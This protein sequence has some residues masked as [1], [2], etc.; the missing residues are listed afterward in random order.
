[1]HEP[2]PAYCDVPLMF[3]QIVEH[4]G[5]GLRHYSKIPRVATNAY[6]TVKYVEKELQSIK[7]IVASKNLKCGWLVRE[8]L[9]A[10]EH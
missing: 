5:E 6:C 8:A 3:C 9:H 4:A 1:M 2:V 10:E 7:P